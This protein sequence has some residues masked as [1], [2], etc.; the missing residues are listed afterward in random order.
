MINLTMQEILTH[1]NQGKIVPIH[2]LQEVKQDIEHLREN[3]PLNNF[4]K[5]IVTD[6]YRF[7]LPELDFEIRSLI[8]VASPSP[9]IVRVT[10]NWKGKR[11]PLIIPATYIDN[12]TAPKEIE[13][14]L[15]EF[16]NPQGHHVKFAP[17]LPRK[18]LAVRSGLGAYGRNNICYVE[19]MGSFH[20]IATYFSDIPCTDEGLHEIHQM[21][22]CET[23]QACLNN[24]P[25]AAITKDR[26]LIN[27]ERCLTYFNEADGKWDFPEWVQPSFHNCIYGCL[28]CQSV[29]PK[30][31]DY[32]DNVIEPVEFTEDEAL[33]LVEGRPLEQFPE[34]LKQKVKELDM[35]DYLTALPRNLKVLLDREA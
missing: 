3:Q 11:I 23:C 12:V 25:T 26:F 4:Q 21:D 17:R 28:R 9:A 27:A 33:L 29:C 24:C 20:N 31:K 35:F 10:F 18:L 30:N 5:S 19:G 15:N 2:C 22:L 13:Q 8:I 7:D 32:L 14:Y 1:G 16:L 34:T 6:H